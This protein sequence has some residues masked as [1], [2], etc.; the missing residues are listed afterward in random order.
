MMIITGTH[1]QPTIIV[2]GIFQIIIGKYS[3]V[4]VFSLLARAVVLSTATNLNL[5]E[6]E[7]RK[8]MAMVMVM[9]MK[10]R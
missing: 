5:V 4:L 2:L 7:R 6:K 9:V 10:K 1:T 3:G 8:K